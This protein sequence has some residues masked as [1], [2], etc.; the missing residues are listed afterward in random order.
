ML[1]I[2][3]DPED[4][5]TGVGG[6][7]H[8]AGILYVNLVSG[9]IAFGAFLGKQAISVDNCTADAPPCGTPEI[10]IPQQNLDAR[11]SHALCSSP[12]GIGPV[13]GPKIA[14]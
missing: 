11:H 13:L 12:I 10:P 9:Q 5:G 6:L 1:L 2:G 14:G 3:T 7:A 8:P 4:V